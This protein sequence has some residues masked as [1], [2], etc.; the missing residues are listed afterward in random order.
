MKRVVVTGVG[1]VTPIGNDADTFWQNIKKGV[2]GIDVVKSFDVSQFKTQIAGEV[3]DLEITDHIDKKDARKMDR[4]TQ[5]GLIAATEAVENSGLDMEKEDPWRVG[6]ITGSGIGGI[7]TFEEQ[8]TNYLQKGPGRVSPFFI[9]MMIGN[10]APCQ[11]AMKFNARGVNENVV[12]ACASSTN[13]I[14]T[15]FRH[16]QYGDNDVIIAGGCEAA[17][18]PTAFAGFC[19]MKAMSTRNDDPQHASRPFD[20]N[21]DGFVLSEGA[22]FIVLEELEHAK[23]RGA[24]IICEMTGYGATDDAYH[25][26]SPIPG[27]EGGA[28]AMELAIKDSGVEPKDI[29]YINAHGTSTKLNDLF[30]TQAIKSVFG[31][32]AYKVAVSSTKSMTGHML[33][34]AGAV[35]AIVCARAIEDSYIPAT[36]NYETP[37][38]ECDLDIVPNV[39][40]EQ[41]VTYAMSNSL[42]FGGHNASIVFKKYTD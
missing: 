10:I 11:I 38:P 12:T 33:G 35:E 42:G 16:I 8:H 17:V 25:I 21:R 39:G 4:F 3:K 30:E 1:A 2:N 9:P 27:G 34:A 32:A 15:A 29:T 31:D 20:A 23:A 14:G 24:H 37:D 36:I 6:V 7:L 18:A 40:R 13:A 5:L 41:E 28:K 19:N 22:A 26:T